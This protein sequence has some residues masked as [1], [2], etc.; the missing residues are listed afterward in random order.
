MLGRKIKG[1]FMRTWTFPK[2]F[3]LLAAVAAMAILMATASVAAQSAPQ[4]DFFGVLISIGEDTLVVRTGGQDVEVP[5]TK[6]TLIRLPRAAEADL[7]N[8][9]VGDALAI[10]REEVDGRI[11]ACAQRPRT[12]GFPP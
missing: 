1:S 5:I 2:K 12:A 10:S 7:T 4:Q 9:E 8:L 11:R 6:D 3:S